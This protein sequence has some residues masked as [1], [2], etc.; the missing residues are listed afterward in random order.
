MARQNKDFESV[1]QSARAVRRFVEESL[2]GGTRRDDIILVASELASNVIRHARTDF[3]VR[4]AVE[5]KLVRLEV[6]N[7][8]S[9]IP[10]VEGL[11][12]RKWGLR[13]IEALADRWGIE[14][15]GTGKTVWVEFTTAT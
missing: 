11:T 8:S 5:E 2:P 14:S 10:A 15:T 3:S 13:I 7:G 9:L 12:E 6:W 1:P 4:L